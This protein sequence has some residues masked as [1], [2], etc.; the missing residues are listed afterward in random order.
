METAYDAKYIKNDNFWEVKK[1]QKCSS[2]WSAMLSCRS[3]MREGCC[4]SVDTG[5]KISI[6]SDPW[7]PKLQNKTP[8]LNTNSSKGLSKVTDLMLQKLLDEM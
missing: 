4:W 5:D 7:V 2:T 3:E 6:V 1:P 8:T